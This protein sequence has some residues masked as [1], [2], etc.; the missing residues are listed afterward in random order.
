MLRQ[1]GLILPV[2]FLDTRTFL[3][4]TSVWDTARGIIITCAEIHVRDSSSLPSFRGPNAAVAEMT[5]L[6]RA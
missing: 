3:H 2:E 6:R 1:S 5:L 4:S